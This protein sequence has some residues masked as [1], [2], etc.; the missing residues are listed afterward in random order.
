[1][2]AILVAATLITL[3]ACGSASEQVAPAST[4]PDTTTSTTTTTVP[5]STTT[6]TVDQ[7][8][9]V[10]VL[11]IAATFTAEKRVE[12]CLSMLRARSSGLPRQM[13][14]DMGVESFEEGFGGLKPEALKTLMTILEECLPE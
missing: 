11:S 9:L 3:T 13:I 5:P 4:A 12:L 14:I 8:E 2:K 10:Q 1:M 7:D 6:T